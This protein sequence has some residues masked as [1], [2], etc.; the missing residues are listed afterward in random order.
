MMLSYADFIRCFENSKARMHILTNMARFPETWKVSAGQAGTAEI[1]TTAG[2]F[3]KRAPSADLL[4]L[5]GDPTLLLRLCMVFTVMPF[6][7]RPIIAVDLVLRKP[8]LNPSARARN[9]VKRFLYS[10]VSHFIHYFKD[11]RDYKLYF[12]IGPERSSFV[13]FKPNIRDLHEVQ[14]NS[15]GEYV[16]CFGRSLRDYDTFFDAMERLP[17]PGAIPEPDFP[18]LRKHGSRFTRP[19]TD[20]PKNVRLLPDD[21]SPDALVRVISGARIVVLPILKSSLVA[22]GVGMYLNA[23]SMKKC[24]IISRRPGASDV[25]TP[26]QA[27]FV[28]PEDPVG[29]ASAIT[30]V[31]EDPA[32]CDHIAAEGYRYAASLGGEPELLQRILESSIKWFQSR[33]QKSDR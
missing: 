3:I 20:L 14:P 15:D 16:L 9:A 25:L 11:L 12:G 18:N 2:E 30:R 29:L 7:R 24:V 5:N 6:R 8:Q 4:L 33:G 17:Y 26:E 31:W 22:S 27:I 13:D 10:R 28:D 32:K 19:L 1:L 21:G 23:M